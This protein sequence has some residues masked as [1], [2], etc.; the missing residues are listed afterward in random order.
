MPD[1]APSPPNA[2]DLARQVAEAQAWMEDGVQRGGLAGDAYAPLVRAF[3]RVLGIFP[4]LVRAMEA[5]REPIT[6]ARWE[7]IERRQEEAATRVFRKASQSVVGAA[8][9][10]A[11]VRLTVGIAAIAAA[12]GAGGFV[13]GRVTASA[14]VASIEAG[15]RMQLGAAAAWV[16]IIR[17]NP[18]PRAAVGA[19]TVRADA[20]GRRYIEGLSLWAEPP[21]PPRR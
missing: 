12:A 20:Q 8:N 11:T 5:S 15:L 21:A 18:D 19:A 4:G 10:Q 6:P 9:R 1:P 16:D 2:E 3:S 17:A 14:E 13:A 7:A